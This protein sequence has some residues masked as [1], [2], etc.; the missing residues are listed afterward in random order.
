[1][2]NRGDKKRKNEK[3]RLRQQ[4][5]WQ[6]PAPPKH[7]ST[8]PSSEAPEPPTPKK[9]DTFALLLFFLAAIL[10]CLQWGLSLIGIAVNLWLGA[11][12]LLLAFV[13]MVWAFWIL[14]RT[15]K[16]NK[17]FKKTIVFGAGI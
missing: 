15:A 3:E 16:W 9:V 5:A 11:I 8:S 14:E 17:R 1:M 7:P 10:A 12:I 6:P 4:S 13:L 2:G